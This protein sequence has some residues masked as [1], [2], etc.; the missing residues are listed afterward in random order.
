[1]NQKLLKENL[2]SKNKWTRALFMIIFLIIFLIAKFLVWI[3]VLF[4]F[5]SHLFTNNVNQSLL[6]FSRNLSF[7]VYQILLFLTYNSEVKPY[8]FTP[9]PKEH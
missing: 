4:Q 2:L 3:I 9:W 1:M 5:I 6:E 8:P 7:Y